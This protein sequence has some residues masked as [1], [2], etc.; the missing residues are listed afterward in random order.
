[1]G[2]TSQLVP[3]PFLADLGR[4]PLVKRL[5]WQVV[6]HG[7]PPEPSICEL[8]SDAVCGAIPAGYLLRGL[9]SR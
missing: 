3:L 2:G 5:Q 4:F 1:M 6:L 7:L 8:G 9:Q